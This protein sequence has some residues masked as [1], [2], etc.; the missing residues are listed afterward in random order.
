MH[1][2]SLIGAMNLCIDGVAYARC[3]INYT[4]SSTY[5]AALAFI[6]VSSV[7]IFGGA[8][9]VSDAGDT[10]SASESGVPPHCPDHRGS[11]HRRRSRSL[12]ARYFSCCASIARRPCTSD[13]CTMA[14]QGLAPTRAVALLPDHAEQAPRQQRP[15]RQLQDPPSAAIPSALTACDNAEPCLD[16]YSPSHPEQQR[17]PAPNNQP[18]SQRILRLTAPPSSSPSRP[19]AAAQPWR[20]S[21]LS[22]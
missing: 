2:I 20:C 18:F 11:G 5:F 13:A 8:S 9:G 10:A 4:R 1:S 19:P 12:R 16:Y 15:Q 14:E 6:S 21:A 17:P 7:P 3:Y 22:C